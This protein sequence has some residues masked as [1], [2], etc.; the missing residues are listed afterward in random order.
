[1]PETKGDSISRIRKS[2]KATTQEAFVTDRY[3]YSVLLK[4]AKLFIKRMDDSWR[5]G[6]YQSL[7]E[8]I[9]CMEMIEVSKI[10]ACCVDIK[11]C[12]T[13]RRSKEKLPSTFEGSTGPILRTVSS[14]DGS[15]LLFRTY[16]STYTRMANTTNFK[17]NKALYYWILNGYLYSPSI[18]WDGISIEGLW[19]D[20]IEMFKC[21]PECCISKQDEPTNIP[22]YLMPDIEQQVRNEI[23]AL[24]QI[25]QEPQI[26]DNVNKLKN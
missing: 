8:T 6:K 19:T 26:A 12:N 24:L 13:V 25:P 1:M 4:Y 20:S 17:Y 16:P 10:E 9:P 23:F 21:D 15:Q 3:I 22:E 18:G 5:L 14:I 11:T 7:F 2:V